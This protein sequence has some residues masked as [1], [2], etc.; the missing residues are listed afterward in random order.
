MNFSVRLLPS[1]GVLLAILA[2]SRQV[3][4]QVAKVAAGRVVLRHW[5]WE[6]CPRLPCLA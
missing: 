3:L 2:L 5:R 6:A 4:D 1:S